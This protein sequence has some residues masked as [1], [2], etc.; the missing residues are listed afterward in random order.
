[1][2]LQRTR[3][4]FT[5]KVRGHIDYIH[6]RSSEFHVTVVSPDF[7]GA[8]YLARHHMHQDHPEA[9]TMLLS[10]DVCEKLNEVIGWEP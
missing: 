2:G 4:L 8:T 7:D 6:A 5:W 10:V 3:R 1:M 9:E